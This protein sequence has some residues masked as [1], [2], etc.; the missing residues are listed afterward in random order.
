MDF[1]QYGFWISQTIG[2]SIEAQMIS[3][4]VKAWPTKS[5]TFADFFEF[6]SSSHL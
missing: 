2:M 1:P 4:K 6:I 5:G 3:Q